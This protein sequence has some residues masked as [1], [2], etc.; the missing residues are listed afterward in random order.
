VGV[1]LRGDDAGREAAQACVAR[2]SA[3]G[4]GFV[5]E[6]RGHRFSG[7]LRA[8]LSRAIAS[9]EQLPDHEYSAPDGDRGQ[10]GEDEKASA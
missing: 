8:A 6:G 2:S 5:R 7:L 1:D 4:H 9:S 10:R 3:V